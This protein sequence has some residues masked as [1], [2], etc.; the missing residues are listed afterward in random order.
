MTNEAHR[1]LDEAVRRHT[2]RNPIKYSDLVVC[3][4][5]ADGPAYFDDD[6]ID[7]C[8]ACGEPVR[9]RPYMPKEPPKV[10]IGCVV[11]YLAAKQEAPPP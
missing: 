11:A 8:A 2:E 5:V 7:Q 3:K 10:C 4:R 6:V 1:A 9:Y